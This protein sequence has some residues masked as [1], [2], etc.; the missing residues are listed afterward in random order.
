MRYLINNS[1]FVCVQMD[2]KEIYQ[3]SVL[4]QVYFQFV[5]RIKSIQTS[6]IYVNVKQAILI[7]QRKIYVK[8]IQ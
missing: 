7:I 8:L 4:N 2:T 5:E 6:L 3:I 1:L